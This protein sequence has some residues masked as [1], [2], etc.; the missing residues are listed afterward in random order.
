MS[1]VTTKKKAGRPPYVLTDEVRAKIIDLTKQ[2]LSQ[3]QVGKAL[4]CPAMV[5]SRACQDAGCSAVLASITKAKSIQNTFNSER[6]KQALDDLLQRALALAPLLD[7]PGSLYN[8]AVG[9]AVLLDKRRLED[10][11]GLSGGG[12]AIMAL[13]SQLS[14]GVAAGE[15]T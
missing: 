4:G 13:L 11:D 9:M 5:V 14:T 8:Y 1:E 12:S 15:T 10:A 7:K 3:R 6:R 2:G